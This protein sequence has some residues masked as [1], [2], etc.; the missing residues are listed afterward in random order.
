MF[1]FSYKLNIA[2]KIIIQSN[3]KGMSLLSFTEFIEIILQTVLILV[4]GKIKQLSAKNNRH[5]DFY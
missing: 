3:L 1:S 5:K 2:D 4:N